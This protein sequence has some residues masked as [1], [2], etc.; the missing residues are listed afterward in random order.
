MHNHDDKYLA[1]PGFE[2]GTTRL[3]APVDT[4]EP[5]GP[6]LLSNTGLMAP[7]WSRHIGNHVINDVIPSDTAKVYI[8]AVCIL[9]CHNLMTLRGKQ[10]LKW[11]YEKETL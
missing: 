1:R 8:K 5:S 3:Q 4:N 2:T 9:F 7:P 6:A 11:S 10:P